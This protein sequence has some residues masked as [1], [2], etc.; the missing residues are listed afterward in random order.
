MEGEEIG[1]DDESM[2]FILEAAGL[3]D[4]RMRNC[5]QAH[6]RR[7]IVLMRPRCKEGLKNGQQLS[8]P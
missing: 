7:V 6:R 1:E 3:G 5:K 2:G 4:A 8:A